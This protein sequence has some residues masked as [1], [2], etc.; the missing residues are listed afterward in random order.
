M[1]A[2]H[3]GHL[4]LMRKARS[5]AGRTGTVVTSIFVNPAQFGPNEDFS[6]YP[7]PFA[8]DS[9]LCEEAGVDVIFNPGADAMY[10]AGHSTYVD[11]GRVSRGLCGASRPGHFR[12]VCTVVLK[13]LNIVGPD[14]AVFGEKDYQQVAVIR[15][16]VADLNVPAR[17]VTAP[18]VRE[19][20]GLALSS[21]NGFLGA[22]ER[23]QAPVIRRALLHA[24]DADYARPADLAR[25]VR[26]KIA[27][28]PLAKIDYVEVLDAKTLEKPGAKTRELVIACAVFFGKTRLIDNVIRT[29]API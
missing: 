17:I 9:R 12:G 18:M 3:A 14:M 4:S 2:L 8:R 7:R 25:L 27:T 6:R 22:E 29:H 28:A 5:L 26:R 13:L 10:A 15:R 23:T 16:M 19:P 11:E 1:G 21:R 20:D 24:R